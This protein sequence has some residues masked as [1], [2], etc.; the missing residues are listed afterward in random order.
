MDI[1]GG[2]KKGWCKVMS[3]SD[4]RENGYK[5]EVEDFNEYDL[6]CNEDHSST[7][8]CPCCGLEIYEASVSG[9]CNSHRQYCPDDDNCGWCSDILYDC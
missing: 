7:G 9:G 6:S 1:F 3:T 8:L 2:Q 5:G 4:A